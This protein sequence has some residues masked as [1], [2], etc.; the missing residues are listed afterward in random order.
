MIVTYVNTIENVSISVESAHLPDGNIFANAGSFG[1]AKNP[2]NGGATERAAPDGR[3]LP[4][5]IDFEWS[6]PP[7]PKNPMQSME[8][9]RALPRKTQR[10]Y[11]R[12]RVPQDIIDEVRESNRQKKPHELS[13]K[14]I[15]IHL[16]WTK[17]GIKFH[18]RL[19]YRPEVGPA[20]FPREGGD[21]L[22]DETVRR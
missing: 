1:Y 21:E 6:E 14:A 16:V 22:T 2:L 3:Q 5:W 11:I 9:Y 17:Q 19:W 20:S 8:E 7:S 12:N 15:W 4:E 10:V 18:W 13:E